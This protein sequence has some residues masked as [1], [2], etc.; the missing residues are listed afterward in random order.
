M[1][2][3]K[4]KKI[5]DFKKV[6][7]HLYKMKEQSAECFIWRFIGDKKFLARVNLSIFRKTKKEFIINPDQKD[8]E[9]YS[10]I[11]GAL[12]EVNFYIPSAALIFRC[13]IKDQTGKGEVVLKIPEFIAQIERRKFPRVSTYSE[14]SAKTYFS[15][16][17]MTNKV[18]TQ[19]FQKTCFDLSA[20]G[21]SI[22]ASKTETQFFQKDENIENVEVT[23]D[24]KKI[25]SIAQVIH[26]QPLEPGENNDIIYKVWK[27]SFKFIK[28]STKDFEFLSRHIFEKLT[29]EDIAI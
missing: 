7:S 14:E 12:D 8:L 9:T 18:N 23:F 13:E 24:G 6:Y 28:L 17:L 11:I 5:Y 21:F 19:Y 10:M 15:K 16:C 27:I 29:K 2:D 4:F 1:M 3:N 20:G 22:L 26:I 25:S